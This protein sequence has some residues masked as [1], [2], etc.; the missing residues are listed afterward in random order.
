MLIRTR[1][2]R[3]SRR[4]AFLTLF[5]VVFI[6]LG[7][8]YLNIPEQFKPTLHVSLRFALDLFPIEVYGWAWVVTGCLAVIG[9]LFHPLDWLGFGAGVVMPFVW[10]GANFAA[11]SD[12]NPR[13]WVGG[14]IYALIGLAMLIVAGMTDPLD[15]EG[16]RRT[17]GWWR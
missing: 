15:I 10:S 3:I 13:A 14:T 16:K 4:D 2:L 1:H 17:I 11:Q 12:I 8:S 9:G 6:L 7:Y 5:G